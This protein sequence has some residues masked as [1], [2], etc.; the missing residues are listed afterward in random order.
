MSEI[1]D[2]GI[3]SERDLIEPAQR[4]F[5]LAFS[6]RSSSAALDR[7]I[8]LARELFPIHDAEQVEAIVK[9][10]AARNPMVACLAAL[11]VMDV[12]DMGDDVAG[13]MLQ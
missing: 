8:R 13:D 6:A 12:A 5:D 2:T 9:L 10:M 4:I 7:V 11:R 1:R 3:P